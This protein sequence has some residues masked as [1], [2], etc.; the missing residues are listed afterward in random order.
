MT[1]IKA[2][3]V[4]YGNVKYTSLLVGNEIQCGLFP[5][6]APQATHGPDLALGL[7]VNSTR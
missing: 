4:G 3:D 5:A 6:L 2:I 1:V 7:V